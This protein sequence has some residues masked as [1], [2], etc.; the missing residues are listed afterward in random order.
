MTP[1]FFGLE[2]QSLSANERALFADIRPAGYIL[3]AR[4]CDSHAQIRQLTDT[5]RALDGRAHLP[6]LIDQEGGRVA[7]LKPP[8]W[9]TFPA[10]RTLG[11][12]Y[13][14]DPARALQAARVNA[15]ALG[16]MLNGLGISVDCLPVLDV[17]A[18]G[19]HD[20]IGDRAYGLTADIV[21]D[22]GRA[23]LEG[24]AQ[25]GI[26]GVIKHIPGHGRA[27][28]DS[29]LSLP[30]VDAPLAALQAV[31]F[32]PFRALA[33]A[34]MAMT[35]HVVYTALDAQHCATLSPRVIAEVIRGFIGFDGLLMSDD[36]GMKALAGDWADL[37]RQT[38]DA[39]CDIVLH[40]SGI[41]EEMTAIAAALPPMAPQAMLRLQ[42]A[43]ASVS[44]VPDLTLAALLDARDSLLA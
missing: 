29:H 38:L 9:P 26:V 24:L 36:L 3:F 42:R 17:P 32:Q 1:V 20:V 25:G 5:L 13:A 41:L 22:L 21:A 39:G 30:I 35:A 34:P 27:G 11:D 37:T 14:Q 7:R 33:D 40:C 16:V 2:G 18:P 12:L 44:P 8:Q 4:N 15:Q 19:A 31:D 28:V 10:G 43:M 6:I 23:T